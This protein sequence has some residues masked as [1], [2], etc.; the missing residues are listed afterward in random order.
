M[1]QIQGM[2][3]L[4]SLENISYRLLATVSEH[5]EDSEN[6]PSLDEF[7]DGLWTLTALV[8]TTEGSVTVTS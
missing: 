2:L 1:G 5:A 4:D 8:I 6:I 3:R 7:L